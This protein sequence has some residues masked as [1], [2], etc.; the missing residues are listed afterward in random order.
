M[1]H[2]R[3]KLIDG[4]RSTKI[5]GRSVWKGTPRITSLSYS[6]IPTF[7]VSPHNGA[8]SNLRKKILVFGSKGLFTADI[9]SFLRISL[10]LKTEIWKS[11]L[12]GE[13]FF[14]CNLFNWFANNLLSNNTCKTSVKCSIWDSQSWLYIRIIKKKTIHIPTDW[15]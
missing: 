8:I 3:E 2:G 9:A 14:P 1:G 15:A 7:L 13:L 5:S 6:P 12:N 4:Q 10:V 11:T